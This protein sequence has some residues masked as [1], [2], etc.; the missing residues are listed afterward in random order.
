MQSGAGIHTVSSMAACYRP[1]DN[2]IVI[3]SYE[4]NTPLPLRTFYFVFDLGTMTAGAQIAC[5]ETGADPNSWQCMYALHANGFTQFFFVSSDF[6]GF[7]AIH[8][9]ALSDGGVLGAVQ[10]LD[11]NPAATNQSYFA[12]VNGTV[13]MI[14]WTPDGVA[15]KSF[16]G[17]SADPACAD[18]TQCNISRPSLQAT[19]LLPPFVHRTV[20]IMSL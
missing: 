1:S 4:V 5:G 8:V 17:V 11:S 7:N 18:N 19:L 20:R 12:A 16:S 13:I 10:T 15:I 3:C 14:G 6:A 9:Q 2:S